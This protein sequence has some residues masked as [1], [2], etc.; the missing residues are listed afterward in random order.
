MYTI[1]L[2]VS[3]NTFTKCFQNK[4]LNNALLA[5]KKLNLFKKSNSPLCSS[6]KK[7]DETVFHLHFYCISCLAFKQNKHISK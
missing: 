4:I 1:L 5:I 2:I 3:S 7:E 6:C